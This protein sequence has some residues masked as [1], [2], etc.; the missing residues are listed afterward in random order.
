V[1]KFAR[2]LVEPYPEIRE[3]DTSPDCIAGLYTFAMAGCSGQFATMAPEEI[4]ESG[5]PFF[6][7]EVLAAM[8]RAGRG[9]ICPSAGL[10]APEYP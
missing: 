8:I 7:R 1:E 6:P 9:A 5:E 4:G 3:I 10:A 2:R